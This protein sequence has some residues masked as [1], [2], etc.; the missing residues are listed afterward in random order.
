MRDVIDAMPIVRALRALSKRRDRA[1]TS[2]FALIGAYVLLS[3]ATPV[4]P[5]LQARLMRAHH[6]RPASLSSWA[7][8][9][10]APKMYGFGHR[11]WIGTF[12][13]FDALPPAEAALRFER[14]H[15]WVN[16]YPVRFARFDG[17][18][19]MAF[20]YP[21]AVKYV[22]IKSSYRGMERTSGYVVRAEPGKL[23]LR[24]MEEQ[25]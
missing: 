7:V 22:Y 13:M 10:L 5:T 1:A 3:L 4:S 6:F 14:E 23:V 2:L 21:G 12:P 19:A 15:F 20:A 24:A 9:Q 18:R 25:P 16:H 8:L 17:W 11:M